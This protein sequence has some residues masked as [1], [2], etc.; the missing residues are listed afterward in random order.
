MADL[1]VRIWHVIYPDNV[2][3]ELIDAPA[4]GIC[5]GQLVS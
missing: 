3:A 2:V 4:Q 5:L 1:A